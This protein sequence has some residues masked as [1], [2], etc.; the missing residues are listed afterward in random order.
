MAGEEPR[1]DTDKDEKITRRRKPTRSS[2]YVRRKIVGQGA[3]LLRV[4][5]SIR[6]HP[7]FNCINPTQNNRAGYA[8]LATSSAIAACTRGL[9]SRYVTPN[10]VLAVGSTRTV[11]C[12][13]ATM[14]ATAAGR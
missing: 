5:G 8:P 3:D 9:S 14:P 11:A 1:M 6:V 13:R 2:A 4:S 7:W 10:Q 12:A